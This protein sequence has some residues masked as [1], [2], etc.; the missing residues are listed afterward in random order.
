MG[1]HQRPETPCGYQ[2]NNVVDTV[3]HFLRALNAH[4]QIVVNEGAF[5]EVLH[6]W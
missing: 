2:N 3:D 6:W 1:C 5:G 4:M